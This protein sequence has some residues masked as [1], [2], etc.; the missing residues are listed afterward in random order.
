MRIQLDRSGH[1]PMYDQIMA[2]ILALIQAGQLRAGDQLPTMRALSDELKV[3]FNT[4]AHAY[5]ELDAA[6]VIRTRRG[7]GTFVNGTA[8]AAAIQRA[9]AQKLRSLV[10]GMLDEAERL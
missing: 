7:Q 10:Q 4:V 9:R 5:R 2:Q 3:N 1:V 8:N 6:G